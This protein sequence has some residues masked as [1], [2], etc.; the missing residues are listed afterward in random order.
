[1]FYHCIIAFA[2][3]M[4]PMYIDQVPNRNSPP[5][6]LLRESVRDGRSVKKKT[7]ANLSHWP[8]AKIETFRRL[9]RDEPLLPATEAFTIEASR[10]HGHVHAILGTIRLLGLDTLIASKRSRQRDLIVGMIAARLLHPGSKLSTVRTWSCTT[11]PD[12]LGVG[13]ADENELY[14]ALDW[15]WARK[16]TLEAKLAKRHLREGALALYDISSSFYYGRHCPLARLGHNRDGNK[17]PIIVYGVLTDGS[18]RPVGVDIY[19]G[20]TGDPKTVPDQAEKLRRRFQLEHIVLVGDRGMITQAQVEHL[21]TY[22]GL[23]WI[24]ALRSDSL[25]KLAAQGQLDRSLFD[26]ENLAEIASPDFP[27][28][29]LMV[30]FNPLLAEE[31]KRKRSELLTATG[32]VLEKIAREVARRTHKPLTAVEIATKVTRNAWRYKMRKHFDVQ[33]AEG[34]FTFARNEASIAREEEMDGFYVIRTSE[35]KEKLSS[36]DTVRAYKRLASVERAFRC[37]K[38]VDLLVRPIYLRNENHVRAHILL[39]VLAYYVEWHMRQALAPLLFADEDLPQQRKLRDPV[40]P[41]EPSAAVVKKRATKKTED[42]FPAH[43]FP[44]LLR[45]LG[46]LCRNT[47]RVKKI[48]GSTHVQ[49]TQPTPLQTRAFQLLGV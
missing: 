44:T 25:R 28:E 30:C 27:G 47:C 15:L 20:N 2:L 48:D 49:D 39:C 21:K 46:T 1:M 11:L 43:S 35:S 12:E 18:G 34:T 31:R 9:L 40:A 14:D 36:A 17:L 33:I 13:D 6:I 32:R 23:G 8:K 38:G 22:P 4:V 26:K 7:L 5:A 24:S 29:R 3:I 10:P 37:L 19:P 41:P 42:G 45:E 16:E